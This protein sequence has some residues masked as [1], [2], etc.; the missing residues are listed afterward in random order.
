VETAIG[1]FLLTLSV[2]VFLAI[3]LWDSKGAVSLD[4]PPERP[5]P[6]PAHRPS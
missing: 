4:E 5:A 3:A 2:V 1:T 6:Q